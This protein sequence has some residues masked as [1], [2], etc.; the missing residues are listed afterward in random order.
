MQTLL[1]RHWPWLVAVGAYWAAAG[2]LIAL[3]LRQDQ[4]NLVYALDD[5]YIHM[6]VAKN[7]VTHGVWGVTRYGFS[8]SV[9]SLLWPLLV[10]LTYEL[11]GVNQASPLVL[12]LFFGALIL[13]VADHILGRYKASSI[14]RAAALLVFMF[15]SI[16]LPMTLQGMEHLLHIA[17]T[18]LVT[19][20]GARYLSDDAD[21]QPSREFRLL[22]LAAPLVTAARFEGMFLILVIGALMVVRL[23]WRH[24]LAFGAAGLLPVAAYGLVSVLKG[25]YLLPNSVLLKGQM[26][27]WGSLWSAV[28]SSLYS[29]IYNLGSAPHLTAIILT[30]LFLYV[31]TS[32]YRAHQ[33]TGWDSRRLMVAIFIG[34]TW[35]HLEFAIVC[36][37]CRYDA[38]L[39]ALGTLIAAAQLID[40]L[41]QE[42]AAFS[43]HW[44][45]LPRYLGAAALAGVLLL[46]LG[47]RAAMAI[48]IWLEGTLNIFQQQY[49]MGLFMQKYYQG[50]TVALNDIGA[51]DFLADVRC[52]DLAGLANLKVARRRLRKDF[53]TADIFELT[54]ESGTRVA[55]VYD[56]WFGGEIGG[57]P[58]EWVKVGEWTIAHNYVAGDKTVSIYAVDAAET[59]PLAQH[60]RDFS[61]SLPPSVLQSGRY[62][63]WVST[64]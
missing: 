12:N 46:P 32:Q 41:P 35:L 9:S 4:G 8:S 54:R 26:P 21:I 7:F 40:L 51:V 59:A 1:K 52:F 14:Y 45:G 13:V 16:L 39:I 18:L 50:S 11:F 64:Q 58:P 57:L 20:L 2:I 22:L 47:T 42:R 60:L 24:A 31:Y 56:S 28:A 37:F 38:Y 48:P 43:F 34:T 36:M 10:V 29:G 6:A 44:R 25:W 33:P 17:A 15:L 3:S 27:A 19:Y 49:H 62:T 63:E 30:V 53:H 5:A 61:A 23:R 55:I